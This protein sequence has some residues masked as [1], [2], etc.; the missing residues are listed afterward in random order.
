MTKVERIRNKLRARFHFVVGEREK[1][2]ETYH[3]DCIR[4]V[5]IETLDRQ[6]ALRFREAA[7]RPVVSGAKP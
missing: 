1:L 3:V 7:R 5:L 6:W 2:Q 4:A